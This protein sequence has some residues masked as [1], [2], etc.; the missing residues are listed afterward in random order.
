MN[1][2]DILNSTAHFLK[3][4]FDMEDWSVDETPPSF[5]L[6]NLYTKDEEEWAYHF[7]PIKDLSG[8]GP[9]FLAPTLKSALHESTEGENLAFFGVCQAPEGDLEG[10]LDP[11]SEYFFLILY[12]ADKDSFY[13]SLYDFD[14]AELGSLDVFQAFPELMEVDFSTEDIVH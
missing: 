7:L 8:V 13:G 1:T 11:E 2:D 4:Y 5:T 6:F 12:L 14:M 3:E 10:R 9:E